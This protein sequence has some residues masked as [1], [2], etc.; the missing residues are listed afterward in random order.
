MSMIKILMERKQG[1]FG[2]EARDEN[3]H[4][5][6]TDSNKENGGTDFGFRPMQLLL[7]ALGSCSAIDIVQILK[8]QRQ[9]IED[10]HITIE[11]E[12]EENVIP[13]L[14]KN[15]FMSFR[16]EGDLGEEK[17]LRACDLSIEK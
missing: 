13:S 4:I 10:I 2:F 8:K 17:G 3:G 1:E 9:K 16:L 15:I 6:Q 14:W 5:I 12:R 7:V 11:G